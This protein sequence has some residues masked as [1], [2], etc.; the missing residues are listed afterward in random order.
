LTRT[1]FTKHAAGTFATLKL[2]HSQLKLQQRL[3]LLK[4]QHPKIP[5]KQRVKQWQFLSMSAKGKESSLNLTG[6][7]ISFVVRIF[8]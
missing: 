1:S 5:I 6:E 4:L 8:I 2:K 7:L 3:L